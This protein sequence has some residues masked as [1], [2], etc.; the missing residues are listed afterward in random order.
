MSTQIPPLALS[1]IIDISVTVSPSSPSV[2]P[3]NIGLFVGPSTIIPS[4][5]ANSRV[6]YFTSTAGVLA[7]GFS[8][9][10]P[11][12][13]A[14]QIYFS[15]SPAAAKFALGRQDLTALQT[16]TVDGRTV[17]DGEMTATSDVLESATADFVLGDV[18]SIIIVEGAGAA[19]AALVTT[20][21][22]YTDPTHVDLTAVAGTTVT[23]AQTSIGF[24]GSGYKAN[25]TV[26]VTQS[27]G[28]YGTVQVLTVGASGQVLTAAVVSGQQGTGYSAT[29]GLATVAVSPSTGSGL[30]V[31]ITAVGETLLQA[32]TA[33][34]AASGLWYGLTVNAPADADN[35]AISEWADPLWQTTRYYP[36]TSDAAVPAGTSGNIALQLQT[37][38]LKVLGQYA[39]TQGGLYPNNVYAAVALMG[40]EMGLQTGLANSFFTVA[41]KTLAQIAPEPLTQTQYQNILSA[42]FNVYGDF[43]AYQLEEPGFMSNGSPSYLWLYLAV[44]V[45]ELQN[46]EMAV[47]QGNPAVAQTNAAQQLLIQAANE[48]C[49]ALAVIG[50]LAEAE[51]EGEPVSIPGVSVQVGQAIQNGYLNQSQP[52][53]QQTTEARDA[54]Q[55]MPVYSFITTAGAVTSLMIAVYT[56]L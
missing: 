45:A 23:A 21:A 44:L 27:G 4:Y 24:T 42:G 9:S 20:I 47:L 7:A 34:R 11:E 12:A 38:N 51:W 16:I 5:G 50:F 35:L 3:F 25:D 56:Q 52:Y 8:P 37:L 39:T 26:T 32:A 18:G 6:Q 19:G 41:H 53:S 1:N 10:S 54:G 48:A 15:Q 36:F 55:A 33:C 49:D 29:T 28:N 30:K 40:V 14:A 22:S 2:N 43:G 31:N 17:V 46:T 13:I